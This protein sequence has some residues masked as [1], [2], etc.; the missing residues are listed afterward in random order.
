MIGET[1][2]FDKT[3]DGMQYAFVS[4][5]PKGVVVKF[6]MYT[7]IHDNVYNLG[8]G[9]FEEGQ[10]DDAVVSNNEDLV[11]IMNTIAS[12]LYAF[13]E[14]YPGSRVYIEPVDS[15]RSNLYHHIF[16]RRFEEIQPL[17]MVKGLTTNGWKDYLP[18]NRYLA[19]E[20]ERRT[21]K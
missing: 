8:F 1:Y 5:G 13:T 18:G 19:F 6:V 3:N 21:E 11:K 17:F 20:L 15:K 12:T 9:D 10:V 14:Q 7:W 16:R 2:Q 4:K